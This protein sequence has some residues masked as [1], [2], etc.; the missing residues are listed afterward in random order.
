MYM[1]T[2]K[3]ERTFSQVCFVYYL[4]KMFC[5]DQMLLTF[6]KVPGDI[7][8]PCTSSNLFVRSS[9]ITCFS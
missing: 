1:Q 9:N 8:E 5:V 6:A 4:N 3:K 2:R 7:Y